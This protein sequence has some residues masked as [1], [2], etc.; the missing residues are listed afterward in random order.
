MAM[1]SHR[2]NTSS[3]DSEM[4]SFPSTTNQ[5]PNFE[6]IGSESPHPFKTSPADDLFLNGKLLPHSFPIQPATSRLS[7]SRTSSISSKDSLMSSRSNSTNSRSS[8]CSSSA[9]TSSSDNSERKILYY[10]RVGSYNNKVATNQGYG[11]SQRWQ[12]II[13]PVPVVDGGCSK[14]RRGR[15]EIKEVTKNGKKASDEKKAGFLRRFFMWFLFTCREC[16]A[17]EP[18]RNNHLHQEEEEQN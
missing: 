17:M 11:S 12:Y 1:E 2:K 3:R 4:F 8:S 16:H 7:T 13:M 10:N 9:R 14:R 18:S 5:D 6:F 15:G